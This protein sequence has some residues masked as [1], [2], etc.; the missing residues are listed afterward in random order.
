[1][2]TSPH[3]AGGASPCSS[4]PGETDSIDRVP[5][6]VGDWLARARAAG[7]IRP[8]PARH[9]VLNLMGLVLL[10]P[11]VLHHI[12]GKL[13]PD[14][15]S[16]AVLAARKRELRAFLHGALAPRPRRTRASEPGVRFGGSSAPARRRGHTAALAAPKGS[17]VASRFARSS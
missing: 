13:L 5:W 7:A 2:V 10:F 3:V 9:T 16:S 6:L 4:P 11:G 8:A 14:E 15:T 17:G 12:P 1:M